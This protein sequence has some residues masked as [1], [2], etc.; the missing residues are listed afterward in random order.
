LFRGSNHALMRAPHPSTELKTT[1][2]AGKW[3]PISPFSLDPLQPGS[4]FPVALIP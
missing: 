1:A 4:H 3:L 2:F